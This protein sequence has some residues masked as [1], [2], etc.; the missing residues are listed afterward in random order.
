MLSVAF[1]IYFYA[2]CRY[3]ECFDAECRGAVIGILQVL[4]TLVEL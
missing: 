4:F 1:I 2:K 3:A